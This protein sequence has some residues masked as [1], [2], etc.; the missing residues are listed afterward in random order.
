MI[1]IWARFFTVLTAADYT[2]QSLFT[3]ATIN[4]ALITHTYIHKHNANSNKYA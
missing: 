3:T 1:R 4:N 2:L